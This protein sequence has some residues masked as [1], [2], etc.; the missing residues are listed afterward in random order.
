LALDMAD[1]WDATAENFFGSVS[2]AKLVEAVR[3]VKGDSTAAALDGMKKAG[4]V[5]AAVA[6]LEGTRW[7]P[8][9]LR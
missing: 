6:A 8:T 4:A 1:W 7:L 9:L 5:T 3:E 2:K